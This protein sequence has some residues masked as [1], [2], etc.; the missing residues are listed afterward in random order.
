MIAQFKYCCG[1]LNAMFLVSLGTRNMDGVQ[2]EVG[3]YQCR[4]CS[5]YTLRGETHAD[6]TDTVFVK[7]L[8]REEGE[9]IRQEV[10]HVAARTEQASG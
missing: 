4:R 5:Q 7:I 9:T 1:G 10:K 2:W 6:R 8:S 3:L